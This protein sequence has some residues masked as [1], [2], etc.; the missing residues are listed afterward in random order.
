VRAFAPVLTERTVVRPD[1][2]RGEARAARWQRIAESAARQCGVSI[3]PTVKPLRMLPAAIEEETGR[4]TFLVGSLGDEARPLRDVLREQKAAGTVRLAILIGPEGDL[5][6]RELEMASAHGAVAVG[7]G[8]LVFRVE[9]AAMFAAAAVA[10][11][12]GAAGN[13]TQAS[14]LCGP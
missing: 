3:V 11:E 2:I 13:V 6:E 10:Y 5:T 12:F 4:G 1:E 7:F 8:P 14:C 9:T